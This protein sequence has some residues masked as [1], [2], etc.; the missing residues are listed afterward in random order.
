MSISSLCVSIQ[1]NHFHLKALLK[2]WEA[3][4]VSPSVWELAHMGFHLISKVNIVLCLFLFLTGCTWLPDSLPLLDSRPQYFQVLPSYRLLP[5]GKVLIKAPCS[6]NTLQF[7]SAQRSSSLQRATSANRSS[8]WGYHCA[9][10]SGD[11]SWRDFRL[12]K[13][14]LAQ[15]WVKGANTTWKEIFPMSNFKALQVLPMLLSKWKVKSLPFKYIFTK[16]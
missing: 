13:S 1:R 6:L 9:S 11:P 7:Q 2:G 5:H 10:V 12:F 3:C 8:V 15:R 16:V 14:Q 4:W